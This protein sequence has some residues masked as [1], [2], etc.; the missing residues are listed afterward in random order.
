[1]SRRGNCFDNAVME[2]FFSTVKT[3]LG[4]RFEA[5]G[6]AK[7]ELCDDIEVSGSQQRRRSTLSQISPAGFERRAAACRAAEL[8][9]PS[10]RIKPTGALGCGWRT[11][12]VA[13]QDFLPDM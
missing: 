9:G 4:E 5:Y 1:M 6:I 10:K 7:E 3:E 2:S 12:V 8:A 11:K 13:H